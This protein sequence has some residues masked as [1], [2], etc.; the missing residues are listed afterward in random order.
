MEPSALAKRVVKQLFRMRIPANP[1]YRMLGLEYQVRRLLLDEAERIFYF[2]PMFE[3][4]CGSVGARFRLELTPDSK[5]PSLTNVTLN[6]GADVRMSARTSFSGA[7][8]AP[9]TPVIEVGDHSYIGHRC[10]LRAGTGI[11]IGKH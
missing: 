7:R 3:S 5:F 1:L 8:R 10:V 4:R 6:L 11:R 2:Q 9:R